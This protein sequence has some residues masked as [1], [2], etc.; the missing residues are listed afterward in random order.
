MAAARRLGM[1]VVIDDKLPRSLNEMTA[2]LVKVKALRPDMLIVSGHS[3]G[4]AT[5]ARQVAE[6]R[7]D[8]PLIAVTHCEAARLIR[9]FQHRVD[10]FLC[11]TQWAGDL[12]YRGPYFGSAADFKNKFLAKFP[13]YRDVP[14]QA[15][16]AAAAIIVWK[17]ALE[18]AGSVD[19]EAIR[20]ALAA[21]NL[22]TFYGPIRFDSTGRNIAKPMYLRQI[23]NGELVTV[24]P[25]EMA[26]KPL[27]ARR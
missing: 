25:R 3:K 7:I 5:L 16:Q 17:D 20:A 6:Q 22:A 9:K 12:N 19:S 10:S 15:A 13:N 23:Q 8:R 1:K 2:T 24:S 4:A 11:P 26:A 21:T 27:R 18:R 14:Y